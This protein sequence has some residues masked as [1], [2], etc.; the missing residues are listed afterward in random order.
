MLETRKRI[1]KGREELSGKTGTHDK[2]I[3]AKFGHISS[4]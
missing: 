4:A 2:K 3:I 1:E